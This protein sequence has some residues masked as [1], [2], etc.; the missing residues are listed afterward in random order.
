MP[1]IDV[2]APAGLLPPARREAL[3]KELVTA[4]LTAE[5]RLT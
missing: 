2:T 5:G 4:L 3:R 1:M